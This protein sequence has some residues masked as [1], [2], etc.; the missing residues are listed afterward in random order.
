M[1]VRRADSIATVTAIVVIGLVLCWCAH[2]GID[3]TIQKM[4]IAAIAGL[5]GFAARGLA[6]RP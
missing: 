5:A 1:S 4:G 6:V 2:C 3:H